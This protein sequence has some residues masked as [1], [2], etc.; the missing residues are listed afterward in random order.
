MFGW[1]FAVMAL[2]LGTDDFLEQYESKGFAHF[3]IIVGFGTWIGALRGRRFDSQRAPKATT[4]HALTLRLV[5]HAA[6]VGVFW[7]LCGGAFYMNGSYTST[8][9]V[10]GKKTTLT[11]AEALHKLY[12]S[13]LELKGEGSKLMEQLRAQYGNRSWTDILAEIRE[14]FANPAV[15]ASEV[16]GVARSATAAE[17][18][19][20]HRDLARQ[21]HPDKVGGSPEA[22]AAA[23]EKMQKLNWAKEVLLGLKDSD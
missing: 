23:E 5:R 14:A 10:T 19:K 18:R 2:V 16:L 21:N 6:A 3:A 9:K 17:V 1:G 13:T 22:Q 12:A 8:D 4:R 15:E 20:A 11:G 7:L